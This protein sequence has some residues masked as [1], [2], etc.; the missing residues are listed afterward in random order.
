GGDVV[1]GMRFAGEGAGQF[2]D[3]V[4]SGEGMQFGLRRRLRDGGE[5]RVLAASFS[6]DEDFHRAAGAWHR[7]AECQMPGPDLQSGSARLPHPR[8]L[9]RGA[10]ATDLGL[11][12][13]E[14]AEPFDGNGEGSFGAS[15]EIRID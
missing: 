8:E 13:A 12:F 10:L 5:D 9:P 15:V 2:E 7:F 6:N 1:D 4:R 3:R 11:E 14:E